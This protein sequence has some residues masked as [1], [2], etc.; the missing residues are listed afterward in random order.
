MVAKDKYAQSSASASSQN[1]LWSQAVSFLQFQTGNAYI[2][3]LGLRY[4]TIYDTLAQDSNMLPDQGVGSL[5]EVVAGA[6]TANVTCG[7]VPNATATL[8]DSA[9]VTRLHVNAEYGQY[10]FAF[11]AAVPHFT[12][13][14]PIEGYGADGRMWGA[15]QS[16]PRP[17]NVSS[18]ESQPSTVES[19]RR[20]CST[21]VHGVSTVAHPV[22]RVKATDRLTWCIYRRC[23]FRSP[24]KSKH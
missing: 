21:Q 12:E 20:D 18:M 9:N 3:T 8:L 19:S 22:G 24:S 17:W 1:Q 4:S 14:S 5:A 6:T 11:T 7:R 23:A 13:D 15:I 2:S 10:H 16:S